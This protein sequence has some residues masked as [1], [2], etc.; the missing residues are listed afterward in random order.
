MNFLIPEWKDPPQ[1]PLIKWPGIHLWQASLNFPA[2]SIEALWELLAESELKRACRFSFERDRQ[3][4]IAGRGLLR[5]IIGQYLGVNPRLLRFAYRTQGKPVLAGPGKDQPLDFSLSHSRDLVLFA[6][7]SKRRIG[8]DIE[9]IRAIPRLDQIIK[10]ICSLDEQ[11]YLQGLTPDRRKEAFFYLWTRREAYLKAKG[12]GLTQLL[13][14]IDLP[15]EKT[16]GPGAGSDEPDRWT[17]NN[18]I[19]SPGYAAALAFQGPVF[20]ISFFRMGSQLACFNP[21]P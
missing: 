1:R 2:A 4:Y 8:V 6:L 14:C 11:V 15:P 12:K 21:Y 10:K 16:A 5:L 3:R 20:P 9:L 7:A 13:E 17:V 19:P 18:F